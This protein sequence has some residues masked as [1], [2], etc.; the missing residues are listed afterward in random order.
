MDLDA[1]TITVHALTRRYAEVL[2]NGD[3]DRR[4]SAVEKIF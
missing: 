1:D 2:E 3:M 4:V